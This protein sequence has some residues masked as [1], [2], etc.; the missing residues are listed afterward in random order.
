MQKDKDDIIA[1]YKEVIH[2]MLLLIS[3]DKVD[4]CAESLTL[5]K[6]LMELGLIGGY[7]RN[8]ERSY[9]TNPKNI[10]TETMVFIN[11]N[12]TIR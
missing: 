11:T 5:Q 8:P 6:R 2:E 3:G 10:K 7:T 12:Y 1:D 9:N 4:A